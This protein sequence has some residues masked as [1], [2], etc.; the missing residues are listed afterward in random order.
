MG[1]GME[2]MGTR[3]EAVR[4]LRDDLASVLLFYMA[5]KPE[6]SNCFRMQLTQRRELLHVLYTGQVPDPNLF[7]VR[8]FVRAQD[9]RLYLGELSL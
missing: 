2:A 4:T 3:M 6:F 7:F 8:E 5:T 9:R 1:A